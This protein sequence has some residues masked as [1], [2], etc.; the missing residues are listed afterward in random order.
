VKLLTETV[1]GPI[2]YGPAVRITPEVLELAFRETRP[3]RRMKKGQRAR[4]RK[5]RGR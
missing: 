4:L 3:G 1:H 2:K 5:L